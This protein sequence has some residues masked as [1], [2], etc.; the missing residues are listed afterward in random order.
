MV[1]NQ[2]EFTMSDEQLG[3]PEIL[4]NVSNTFHNIVNVSL[5]EHHEY[6]SLSTE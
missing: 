2:N 6:H 3:L 5:T 1:K 4:L